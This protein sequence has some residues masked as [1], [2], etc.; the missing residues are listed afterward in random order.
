MSDSSSRAIEFVF[1]VKN[2]EDLKSS[3]NLRVRSV[4][5]VS[6]MSVHHVEEILN[7]T[8]IFIWLINGKTYFVSIAGSSD[9][10]GATKDSV[11]MLVSFLFVVVD[12]GTNIGRVG[13]RVEG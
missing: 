5:L 8:K 10:G 12:I 4:V 11:N 7:I 13:F 6:D 1:S 3:D 9:C 2:E